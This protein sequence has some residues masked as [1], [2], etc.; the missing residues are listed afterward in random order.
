MLKMAKIYGQAGSTKNLLK[1][2][3]KYHSGLHTL[4]KIKHFKANFDQI[5]ASAKTQAETDIDTRIN[6]LEQ[7]IEKYSEKLTVGD[8]RDR[9]KI[10]WK[11]AIRP[12]LKIIRKRTQKSLRKLI[13]NKSDLI[14]DRLKYLHSAREAILRN[15]PLLL[16]AVGEEQVIDALQTLSGDFIVFNDVNV[17]LGK[18]VN[19]KMGRK[20][21]RKAQID[22]VVVCRGGL[23][24][25]ETK[26][27]AQSSM[28]AAVM[29]GKHPGIQ[30]QRAEFV[31]WVW[32]KRSLNVEPPKMKTV[33]VTTRY[34]TIP[35]REFVKILP[36]SEMAEHLNWYLENRKYL[37][38]KH[39][40]EI[41]RLLRKITQS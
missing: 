31:L 41:P 32:L 23:F 35:P 20:Y 29:G 34:L 8:N 39:M 1:L 15:N 4:E 24:V 16:G 9:F 7:T 21:V 38:N 14:R 2:T 25:I 30:A 19:W 33:V 22:H 37:S 27:Y 17:N 10:L 40:N 13:G 6:N 12:G 18:K 5:L 36:V 3:H 11:L 26:N 28:D